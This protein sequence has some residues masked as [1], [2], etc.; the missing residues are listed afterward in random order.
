MMNAMA[1]MSLC[2]AG[3]GEGADVGAGRNRRGVGEITRMEVHRRSY[4]FQ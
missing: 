3:F 1:G 2:K 4:C